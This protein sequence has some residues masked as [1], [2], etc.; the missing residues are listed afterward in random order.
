MQRS[1]GIHG[2]LLI[3]LY[4]EASLVFV[5]VY[6]CVC[7]GGGCVHINSTSKLNMWIIERVQMQ[8]VK[9]KVDLSCK[10]IDVS[11]SL[12]TPDHV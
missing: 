10:G 6:V 2:V 4:K 11:C 7:G 3:S 12:E 8:H 1:L 9:K 5:S